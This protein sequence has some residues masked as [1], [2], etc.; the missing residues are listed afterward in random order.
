MNKL[1]FF[2]LA[3]L[4][5]SVTATSALAY[6]DCNAG[7]YGNG[8][9]GGQYGGYYAGS[10]YTYSRYAYSS[11]SPV[12]TSVSYSGYARYPHSWYN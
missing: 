5:L 11:V 8:V 3:A 10:T 12:Y 4:M 6:I 7:Y 1:L 2:I 9:Y